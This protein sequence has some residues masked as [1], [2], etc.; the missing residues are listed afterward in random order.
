M[1][2]A[3]HHRKMIK[4]PVLAIT[5]TNGKTTTK[6]LIAAIMSKKLNVHFKGNLNNE[7]GLPLTI[8][9]APEIPK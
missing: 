2:L 4:A 5:E 9:S 6:E 1:A 7:I 8:L 3:A